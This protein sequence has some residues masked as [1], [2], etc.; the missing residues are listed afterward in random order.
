MINEPKTY[1]SVVESYFCDFDAFG[2]E[3]FDNID[4]GVP[5]CSL[6]ELAG[7]VEVPSIGVVENDGWAYIVCKEHFVN[8]PSTVLTGSGK[9]V[10]NNVL[11]WAEL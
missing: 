4:L 8:A 9:C 5:E 2:R 1:P 7:A 3:Y 10:L 6:C 11:L